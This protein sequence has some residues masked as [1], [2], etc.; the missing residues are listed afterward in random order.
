MARFRTYG[1]ACSNK[2]TLGSK[3]SPTRI[4]SARLSH[5]A[6]YRN[7]RKSVVGGKGLRRVQGHIT[8]VQNSVSNKY[9]GNVTSATERTPSP[10]PHEQLVYLTEQSKNYLAGTSPRDCNRCLED[11]T[12]GLQGHP[13][14]QTLDAATSDSRRYP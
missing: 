8:D 14:K 3:K 12:V 10:T 5:S 9:L 13:T 1:H 4:L 11:W 2:S 7:N 6:Q